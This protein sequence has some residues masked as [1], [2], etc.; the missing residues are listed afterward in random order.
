MIYYKLLQIVTSKYRKKEILNIVQLLSIKK[1]KKKTARTHTHA[2]NVN[3][4]KTTIAFTL[5]FG[6]S[7]LHLPLKHKDEH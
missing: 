3:L 1:R 5:R 7:G 2:R 6:L 4:V